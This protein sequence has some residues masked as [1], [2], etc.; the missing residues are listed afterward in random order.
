MRC[1]S[2]QISATKKLKKSKSLPPDPGACS[3]DTSGSARGTPKDLEA[4]KVVLL[5][6]SDR[7]KISL[8]IFLQLGDKCSQTIKMAEMRRVSLPGSASRIML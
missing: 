3:V 4:L 1:N 7:T 6:V 8:M 2:Q 5:T